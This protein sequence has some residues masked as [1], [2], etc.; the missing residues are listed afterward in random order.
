MSFPFVPTVPLAVALWAAADPAEPLEP[1]VLVILS[2]DMGYSDLGC[3]GGE[4]RT[5]SLDTLPAGGLQFTQF[6]TVQPNSV[7]VFG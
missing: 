1:N 6:V 3:Y 4:I 7:V 2:D 5:P